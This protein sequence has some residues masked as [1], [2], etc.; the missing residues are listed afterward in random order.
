MGKAILITSGKGGVGKSTICAAI[1]LD[2]AGRGKRVVL[3]DADVGLRCA[4]LMLHMQDRVVYDMGDY[5]EGNAGLE[6]VLVTHPYYPTLLLMA[7]PQLMSASDIKKKEMRALMSRLK[8]QNDFVLIDGPAGIGRSTRNA[9]FCADE[10]ILVCTPD[11][12]SVRDG[13]R[14]VQV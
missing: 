5:L 6:Q 9:F 13:E 2:L 1:A 3:A 8:E 10:V 12:I 7:A 11:D 4:D 14:V